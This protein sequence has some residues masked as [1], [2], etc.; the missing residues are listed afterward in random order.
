VDIILT[1]K[2]IGLPVFALVMFAV[3]WISQAGPGVWIAEG[4]E[5]SNGTTLP[6]LVTLCEAFQ[7]WVA[8][9]FEN[10]NPLLS[11]LLVDVCRVFLCVV[12]EICDAVV[13]PVQLLSVFPE[14]VLLHGNVFH[15]IH[16]VIVTSGSDKESVYV[17]IS[18]PRRNS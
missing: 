18:I 8:G 11:A 6:G 2:W 16:S 9:F 5:L 3:F 4:L 14:D 17:V 15:V 10:A 1:N 7:E 13:V 12:V